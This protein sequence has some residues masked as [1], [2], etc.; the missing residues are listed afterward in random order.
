MKELYSS[1]DSFM[2]EVFNLFKTSYPVFMFEFSGVYG[3]VAANSKQ[4]VKA[5]DAAKN[6]LPHKFYSSVLGSHQILD[7]AIPNQLFSLKEQVFETFEGSFIRFLLEKRET[8]NALICNG[9]HQVLIKRPFYRNIFNQLEN[10]LS[11][12]MEPSP[13]FSFKYF[14]PICSSANISGD[15]AG[16]IT[17]KQ[18]ALQFAKERNIKLFVH[19]KLNTNEQGSYPVFSIDENFKVKIERKGLNDQLIL[20][21][22]NRLFNNQEI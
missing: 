12:F 2:N 10:E 3:L 22:A 9:T 15:I 5:I 21:K 8:N 6:R 13:Y 11:K 16:S 7:Y 19:S 14:S 4:G 20:G 18:K 1:D 17:S